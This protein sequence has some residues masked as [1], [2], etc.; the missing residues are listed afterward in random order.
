MSANDTRTTDI[1][2][3]PPEKG[4]IESSLSDTIR[5]EYDGKALDGD[6]RAQ[7]LADHQHHLV[8]NTKSTITLHPDI[9]P[10]VEANVT[11][12]VPDTYCFTC[13]E[14]VGLS[15]VDLTGTPRSKHDAYYLGGPPESV[16]DLQ[17]RV[18]HA[19]THLTGTVLN[20]HPHIDD[21]D[22]AAEFIA[23][24]IEQLSSRL[25]VEDS[26]NDDS[27]GTDS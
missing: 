15:G 20:R 26:E 17:H 6:E 18:R 11:V 22:E 12:T 10:G 2:Q 1:E 8:R 9:G 16:S 21:A 14:W 7:A 5:D 27:R 25:V 4:E 24:E 3:T 13:G 23:D 19:V